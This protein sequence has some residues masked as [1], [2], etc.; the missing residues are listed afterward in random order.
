MQPVASANNKKR[1]RLLGD[2]GLG[3]ESNASPPDN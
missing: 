3:G 2:M 1:G